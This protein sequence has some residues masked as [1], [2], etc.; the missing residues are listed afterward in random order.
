[1][2]ENKAVR[3]QLKDYASSGNTND[4][5]YTGGRHGA[6]RALHPTSSKVKKCIPLRYMLQ[7]PTKHALWTELGDDSP[8][9]ISGGSRRGC[10]TTRPKH[11]RKRTR[12]KIGQAQ[13]KIAQ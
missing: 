7:K 5:G 10:A 1:M 11:I 4:E 3:L 9:Y 2:R 12:D 6:P 13:S 8:T